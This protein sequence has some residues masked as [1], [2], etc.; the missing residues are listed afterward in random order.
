MQT[1]IGA[2]WV[3]EALPTFPAPVWRVSWSITGSV[4]AVACGDNSVT[5]FKEALSDGGSGGGGGGG[6]WQQVSTVPD[7]SI[8]PAPTAAAAAASSSSSAPTMTGVHHQQHQ[9]QYSA[10][11]QIYH[12]TR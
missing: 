8:V 4:L 12:A 6:H 1:A 2:D 10:S 5:L 9:Q 11:G 3:P 7:A